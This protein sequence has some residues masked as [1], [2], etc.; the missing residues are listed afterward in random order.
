MTTDMADANEDSFP[1]KPPNSS[2]SQFDEASDPTDEAQDFRFL[3]TVNDVYAQPD[4][5]IPKR[6]EKDFEPLPLQ[7]QASALDAS[8]QAM[9]NALSYPRVHAP[10]T[11]IAG[12]LLDESIGLDDDPSDAVIEAESN[13]ENGWKGRCVRVDTDEFRTVYARSMGSANSQNQIWLWPEEALFLV[14]RGTLDLRWPDVP[15]P[16]QEL[17]ET[18]EQEVS[19]LGAQASTSIEDTMEADEAQNPTDIRPK[20]L[21]MSLQAAY[22]RLIGLSGLTLD[23]YTVYAGLRRSGYV[24]TRASTWDDL[25]S[26]A[27]GHT[28]SPA[29][30]TDSGSQIRTSFSSQQSQIGAPLSLIRRLVSWLLT[31]RRGPSCPAFGPLVAPGLYR[32]Y[33]DIFRALALIPSH[34]SNNPLPVSSSDAT[35]Q[36]QPKSP[37]RIAF[38]VFKPTTPYKKSAPP[39]PDFRVAVLDARESSVPRLDEIGTL[40]DSMPADCLATDKRLEQRIK[41]GTRNVIL[42]VVDCGVVSFLRFSEAEIGSHKLYESKGAKSR[43]KKGRGWNPRGRGKK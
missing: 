7:S 4:P 19:S 25:E 23:R 27:N 17:A 2:Q 11:R 18:A 33:E 5:T 20:G 30:V 34:S 37:F 39:P 26:E 36:H 12:W 14:E 9:H 10:K 1:S 38:D 8:R 43:V 41:H 24:V 3:S 42:A 6:G 21:P 15:D 40:L 35:I 13:A 28:Q 22:A 31:P 29:P 32:S 16:E